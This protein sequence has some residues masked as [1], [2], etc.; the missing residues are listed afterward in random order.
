MNLV[1]LLLTLLA[2]VSITLFEAVLILMLLYYSFLCIKRR[3]IPKGILM[4]PLLLYAIP[5]LLSTLIFAP[6]L[7]GKGIERSLFLFLYAA[8]SRVKA[9]EGYLYRLNL[10]L[11]LIGVALTPVIL[12]KFITAGEPAP[13][14]GGWFE[15]GTFYS[16]FSLSSLSLFLK[17]RRLKHLMLFFFFISLVFFSSRRS[18]MLGL[19]ITLVLFFFLIRRLIRLRYMIALWVSFL[20]IGMSFSYLFVQRDVRFQVLYR[21]FV[22]DQ[23]LNQETLN[24]ISSVR[25]NN[26]KAG[27]EVIKGDVQKVDLLPLLIGHGI[28]PG[29]RLDVKP[30]IGSTYESVIFVSELIERGIL[31]IVGILWIFFVYFSF[32]FRFKVKEFLLLPFLLMPSVMFIGSLF[33]GFWDAL[34]PLYLLYF[35]MV[36]K[37]GRP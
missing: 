24:T 17:T 33:T 28:N 27:I 3:E 35:R 23:E 32:L 29:E 34:L 1:V 5:T 22:G 31:G 25:L 21:V 4:V 37:Y 9:D 13:L 20:L 14:W 16:L 30:A 19:G 15:V 36:E 2:F 26:L 18:V 8:G 11:I 12:Y 10:L 6:N 7:M